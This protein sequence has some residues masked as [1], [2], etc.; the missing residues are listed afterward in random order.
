MP[1]RFQTSRNT[2]ALVPECAP[3]DPMAVPCHGYLMIFVETAEERIRG[4]EGLGKLGPAAHSLVRYMP[5][6]LEHDPS[7]NVRLAL[8]RAMGELGENGGQAA[9][10]LQHITGHSDPR[11][12]AAAEASLAKLRAN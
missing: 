1:A 8:V 11:F 3:E 9:V 6:I 10:M 12:R 5:W 4:I 2:A 7:R